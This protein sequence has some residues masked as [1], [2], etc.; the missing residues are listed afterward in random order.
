M[1]L[2]DS[3]ERYQAALRTINGLIDPAPSY[4]KSLAEIHARAE[5]RLTRLKAFLDYLGRPQDAYPIVHVAGTSGKGSTSTAAAA[6]LTASG[7]RTGLHTS[8]YLQVATE[9]A[10]IDGVLIDG[11][12]FASL[13]EEL[14]EAASTWNG[15]RLTYAELW[16]ALVLTSFARE[17]VE[18]AVIEVGAGGRFD[19]TNV[20]EPAVSVITSIGIDHTETLGETIEEI[21]WHK[22]GIIKPGRPAVSAVIEP[23]PAGII[24]AE[25]AKT[26]SALSV[27]D[28]RVLNDAEMGE[29]GKLRWRHGDLKLTAA[30][31]GA[32]Q[33]INGETAI[34]AVERLGV[35]ITERGIVDGIAAAKLPGRL[36]LV[37]EA[38]RV[39]L[40]G[41]HNPQK[42]AA[43]AGELPRMHGNGQ[44]RLI[45][46]LGA[47][48]AKDQSA[49]VA[50]IAAHADV[51]V[52]TRPYVF[53]KPGADP[54]RLAGFARSAGFTGELHEIEKPLE[55]VDLAIG[56]ADPARGDTV[57]VTGSLYL[58]GNVR[59]RWYPSAEIVRQRTSWP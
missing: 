30:M 28:R 8:P 3:F 14:V 23:V 47:L 38:P 57:L 7:Y 2:N 45:A 11:E 51:L 32:F 10:A 59:E 29:D 21:A 55:A 43:L 50:G 36:E 53:A 18:A 12:M 24:A 58:V 1:P 27:V 40:D 35:R 34:A 5:V 44:G 39:Y 42:V 48:E 52:L 41:A 4:G 49:I 6:I 25:A 37:Q 22:A 9:K 31:P 20:I 19:L 13:V 17:R 26:G 56:L 15:E 46:V 54:S 33:A 16:V